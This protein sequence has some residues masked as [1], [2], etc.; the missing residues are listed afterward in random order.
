MNFMVCGRDF[1]SSSG[2]ERYG[3]IKSSS[4]STAL[5]QAARL[6]KRFNPD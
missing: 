1:I 2:A 3:L 4:R 6:P 5:H